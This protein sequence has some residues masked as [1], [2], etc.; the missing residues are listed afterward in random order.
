MRSFAVC[1]PVASERTDNMSSPSE[2]AGAR[3]DLAGAMARV[4]SATSVESRSRAAPEELSNATRPVAPRVEFDPVKVRENLELAI[5]HMNKQLASSGRS[6]GFTFDDVLN[7][8]VVTVKNT[9]TGE[10]IRQIPNEAVIRVAHTLDA[11]KGL[12]HDEST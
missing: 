8:P 11:L 3:P 9:S 2:V 1:A 4:P 7:R 10:V 12:L 6:L 5:E